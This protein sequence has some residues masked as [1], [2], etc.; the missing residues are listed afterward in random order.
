MIGVW[1]RLERAC[2]G[3]L[4]ALLLC[5]CSAEEPVARKPAGSEPGVLVIY[6]VNYP[7]AFFAERIAGDQAEVRFPVPSGI[8][9]ADWS[10]TPEDVAAFQQADLILLNGGGYAHWLQHA[11]LPR[12]SRIDTGFSIRDRL[13]ELREE[14]SHAHGP[15]GAHSHTGTAATTWLD[16]RLAAE[17]AR[18]IADALS[19]VRP[20]ETSGFSQ[21]LAALE[22]D[23]VQLD[24]QFSVA[25][26]KFGEKP[27]LFSHPVYAYFEQRYGLNGRSLHWE[28]GEVPEPKMWRALEASLESHPARLMIWEAEPSAETVRRLDALG[29][30]TAVFSPCAN[31]PT[32]GNWLSAMRSAAATLGKMGDLRAPP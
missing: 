31:T 2:R 25:T 27:L 7:L 4:L 15:A 21:R 10:P 24:D 5:A 1:S 26:A 18:A 20:S 6:A 8:D 14:T 28:P 32:Q 22:T 23:L 12:G 16:P 9:P 11:S 29:I 3:G 30:R 13:I 17:Q 19:R